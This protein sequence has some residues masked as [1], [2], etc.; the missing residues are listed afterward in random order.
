[1]DSLYFAAMNNRRIS[2]AKAYERLSEIMPSTAGEAICRRAHDGINVAKAVK[3]IMGNQRADDADVPASFWW[4]RGGS[5]MIQ[6]WQ[7]GDFETWI[8]RHLHCRAYGVSFLETDIDAMLPASATSP[9]LRGEYAPTSQCVDAL[10]A[11]TGLSR[12]RIE[13]EILSH[14]AAGMIA[15][16]CAKLQDEFETRHGKDAGQL[17]NAA[18]P[19]FI[20]RDCLCGP[21]TIMNWAAGRFSG[22]GQVE[23]DW[24]NVRLSGV[25][26]CVEHL[27]HLEQHLIR[28]SASPVVQDEQKSQQPSSSP[29]GRKPIYDW[30]AATNAIWGQIYRGQFTPQTQ[31]EIETALMVFL[32][33]GDKEPSESTVRPHARQIWEQ[34]EIEA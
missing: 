29:K 34:M 2:A 24:H 5:A 19:Y 9:R 6:N 22:S 3:L 31:A 17:E 21:D 18:V 11:T 15:A 20:W 10:C 30:Q 28:N 8:D 32:R 12:T 27:R 13:A 14:C 25:E 33:K 4:S 1:V 23:D 26:F 16:R 7:S